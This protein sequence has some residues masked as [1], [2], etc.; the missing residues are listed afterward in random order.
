MTYNHLDIFFITI[1]FELY[2]FF[3]F[4]EN[5]TAQA[6]EARKE[7]IHLVA[8]GVG[9]SIRELELRGI[10][11]DPDDVNV[12]TV[13]DFNALTGILNGLLD[14]VCNSMFRDFFL[15]ESDNNVYSKLWFMCS[16]R[17]S[18][19]IMLRTKHE[20]CIIRTIVF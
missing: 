14:G 6:V 11:T 19:M 7:G 18:Y 20:K 1:Y 10:T 8:I 4:S 13:R 9:A 15:N 2:L 17:Y 3:I 16:I 12:F 5:T